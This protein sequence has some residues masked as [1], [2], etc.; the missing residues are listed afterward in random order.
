MTTKATLIRLP[1]QGRDWTLDGPG[2][3]LRVEGLRELRTDEARLVR[4]LPACAGRVLIP[5][6]DS[7]PLIPAV[8]ARLNPG[9]TVEVSVLDLHDER[10]LRNKLLPFRRVQVVCAADATASP[11]AAQT[12]ILLLHDRTDRLLAWDLIER[13]DQILPAGSPVVVLAPGKR[14]GD[15]TA[16][17]G[18]HFNKLQVLGVIWKGLAGGASQDWTPRWCEFAATTPTEQVRLFSR[19]G[20]FAHSRPDSG[21]LALAERVEV[22]P[23]QR[24]LELGCGCGLTGLLL[25]ERLRLTGAT[26]TGEIILVDSNA[27]AVECARRG[28]EVNGCS[29]VRVLHNDL[30]Q[31]EPASFDVVLGNPPYY[32][33]HRIAQYFIEVAARALKPGGRLWLVSK[34]G[35]TIAGLAAGYGFAVE[36]SRRRGYDI[37]VGRKGG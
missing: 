22:Q 26:V 3:P 21:G 1:G 12:G 16:K 30:Y 34:H 20:V 15:Y 35:A 14:I 8:I 13:L 18:Q 17:L 31:P 33:G 37:S 4:H 28:A 24:I 36:T 5:L 11:A 2:G 19:P 7:S 32:A 6:T 29:F 23:D 27:R 25:A 10:L 9:A